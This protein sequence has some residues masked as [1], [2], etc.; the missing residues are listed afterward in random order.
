MVK[1]LIG[2]VSMIALGAIIYLAVMLIL[3][4]EKIFEATNLVLGAI[5]R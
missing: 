4:K 3:A 5:K 1:G 2:V